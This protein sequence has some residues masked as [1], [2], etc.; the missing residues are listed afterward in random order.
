MG[1]DNYWT[2]NGAA[3]DSEPTIA[4]DF[5]PPLQ[6]GPSG[7]LFDDGWF[8]GK[9]YNPL[10]E[11]LTGISLYTKIIHNHTVHEMADTLAAVT[12]KEAIDQYQ[13]APVATGTPNPDITRREYTDLQRMFCAYADAGAQLEAWY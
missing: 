12:Y 1:L 3:W 7:D 9:R 6:L 2:P 8:R 11:T 13:R 4:I 10:V 5:E